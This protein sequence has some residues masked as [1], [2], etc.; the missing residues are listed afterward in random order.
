[1]ADDSGRFEIPGIET[2]II[3]TK[4]VRVEAY[5][6]DEVTGAITDVPDRFVATASTPDAVWSAAADIT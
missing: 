4:P 5:G 2:R 1:M 3:Y 6:I